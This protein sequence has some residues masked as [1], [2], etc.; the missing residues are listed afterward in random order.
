MEGGEAPGGV[1]GVMLER[2]FALTLTGRLAQ[3]ELERFLRAPPFRGVKREGDLLRGEIVAE[4]LLFGELALPFAS[5]LEGNRLLSLPLEPP[6]AEL[7]GVAEE[8]E[9]LTL[10]L[11]LRLHLPQGPKWGSRAFLPIAERILD[12]VLEKALAQYASP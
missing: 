8:G 9:G 12:R 4:N 10:R 2:S 6:Y 5:R 7:F 1:G 3:L 11:T